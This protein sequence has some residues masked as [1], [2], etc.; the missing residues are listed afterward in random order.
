[1][2]FKA[3]DVRPLTVQANQIVMTVEGVLSA[4]LLVHCALIAK[5]DGWDVL[6]RHVA[7][8]ALKML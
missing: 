4:I 2:F 5:K 8:M 7:R 3:E 1:M 6:V